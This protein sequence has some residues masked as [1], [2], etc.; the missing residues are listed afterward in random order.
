MGGYTTEQ[1]YSKWLHDGPL[2]WSWQKVMSQATKSS[3]PCGFLFPLP[4]LVIMWLC[5]LVTIGMRKHNCAHTFIFSPPR[6]HRIRCGSLY[7]CTAPQ[8][9]CKTVALLLL[10]EQCRNTMHREKP[11]MAPWTTNLHLFNMKKYK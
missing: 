4:N 1:I 3:R 9:N 5:V 11:S 10:L 7:S 2:A 8:N 6:S